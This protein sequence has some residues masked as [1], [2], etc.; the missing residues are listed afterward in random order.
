MK[1]EV[2]T[3][4][5]GGK[6]GAGVK[7]AG[8][9]ASHLFA[10]MGRRVFQMDDYQSL[11]KG[12]HNFSV[13]S[14]STDTIYSH[15]MKA[16]L[17][18]AL[19]GR[20]YEIH[21]NHLAE[22]GTMVFN[23][24][25]I[26]HGDGI[27]IP[28]KSEAKKFPNPE[29]RIGISGV[30]ILAAAIGFD[31]G[32]LAKI[33]KEE[34]KVDLDNNI[35][36]A[37]NIYDH[38]YKQIKGKFSLTERAKKRPIITGNEAIALGATAAGL[39]IYFAYPMTPSNSILHF[40]AAHEKK[41]NIVTIHPENEIA[42]ANMAIGSAF[43][44]ARVMVGTS[45]GGFA[46]MEEAFSLAGMTETPFLG[47]LGSRPGPSTGLPTYS[48]QADLFFALNQGHGEFPKIVASPGSIEESFYLAAEM[49]NLVWIFQTPGILL[50]EKHMAESSMTVT[51][52]PQK[53]TWS[54]PKLH[55]SGEYKRYLYTDDGI[56]P[57]LFPPAKEWINWNSYEHDEMGVTTESP[58]ITIQMR[59]KRNRKLN[60][61]LKHMKKMKTVN[62]FGTNGPVIFTYGSTTMS[63]LEALQAGGIEATVIQLIYL[64]PFPI[65]ELNAYKG[66]KAI[67]VEQSSTAQF[68]TLLEE[69]AGIKALSVIKKYDGRPF[70]PVEL[71]DELK[72]VM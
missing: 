64:K 68:A 15:Y 14:T 56:S 63:V 58:E 9:V 17:I 54:E 59:D 8:N 19:D 70:D 43:A 71:A 5:V 49:L 48:D 20:S 13:I 30:A 65:W 22:K 18:V 33:I 67:I 31:K 26:K 42:V 25:E 45:G 23:Y 34:Y 41:L 52:D 51:L 61:I 12:G 44:G 69:K 3:F 1:K 39:D 53:I 24:D 11:I 16:D 28:M 21:K 10:S 62:K 29:L 27:G 7:K 55:K 4:I 37:S 47:Y 35:S 46:L 38:I 36:F 32:R 6:A 72:E 50:T 2:F 57:L 60:T 66:Q 40:L